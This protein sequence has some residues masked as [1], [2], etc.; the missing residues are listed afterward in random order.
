MGSTFLNP[1]SLAD[2]HENSSAIAGEK[3]IIRNV[4]HF[5]R[6]I[7]ELLKRRHRLS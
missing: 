3:L 4:Q 6:L 2:V 5:W 1:S 7:T